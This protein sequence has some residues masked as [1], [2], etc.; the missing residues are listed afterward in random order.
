MMM[1]FKTLYT[2]AVIFQILLNIE[3][4]EICKLLGLKLN[5]GQLIID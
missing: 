5:I 1:S 4:E 2:F 3:K